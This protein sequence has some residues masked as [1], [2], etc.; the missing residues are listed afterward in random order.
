MIA[1]AM[2][3]SQTKLPLHSFISQL[4]TQKFTSFVANGKQDCPKLI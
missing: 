2:L 4:K 3:A 1:Q